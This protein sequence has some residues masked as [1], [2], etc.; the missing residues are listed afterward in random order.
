MSIDNP[1]AQWWLISTKFKGQIILIS[2]LG[3]LFLEVISED[4][5]FLLLVFIQNFWHDCLYAFKDH[6]APDRHGAIATTGMNIS[7]ECEHG[8]YVACEHLA[9]AEVLRVDHQDKLV[10][11]HGHGY[12]QTVREVTE[13]AQKVL[14]RDLLKIE[15][16]KQNIKQR[17]SLSVVVARSH[18][19]IQGNDVLKLIQS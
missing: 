16:T 2:Q 11:I 15:I 7:L 12:T 14:L 6:I 10:N 19:A 18:K 13:V 5:Y 9:V 8:F 4:T 3:H 17:S 1:F